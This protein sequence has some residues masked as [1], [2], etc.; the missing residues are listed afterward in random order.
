MKK[1][2]EIEKLKKI[3]EPLLLLLQTLL[4]VTLTLLCVVPFSCKV[5]EEGIIFVGGDYVS[6]VLEEVLVLDEKNVM[7]TFSEKIKL[8]SF[9]V[10][11]RLKEISDSSEH[12]DTLELSPALRAASGAYGR[13]E[14]ECFL[15]E[16]GCTITC[17]AVDRYEVG[18]AYE[19][20]GTV[21]DRAGNSLTYC[22]PFTG[23]N[24]CVPQ[25]IIT[26]VQI[27]GAKGSQNG[28]PIFR[29]EFVE[30]LALT[31]GNL[32]GLELVGGADGEA[33][34]Y[35][36]PPM[37]VSKGEVFLVHLRTSGD[38]CVN[39]LEEDLNAATAPHSAKGIR[40]LWSEN[41]AARLN[42]SSDV[43]I[44]RNSISDKLLDAFMYA[45]EDEVEWKKGRSELARAAVEAGIYSTGDISEAVLNVKTSPLKS[46]SRLDANDIR[47]LALSG[48]SYE[49]PV[50][51]AVDNWVVKE[52]SPGML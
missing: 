42:D 18:K 13:V 24:S 30:F 25:L 1:I 4:L 19:I 20:L 50:R 39:E 45:V 3:R 33:K 34:K 17:S 9:T 32:A 38:G 48:Q 52:T 11:E 28:N 10:S 23:F 35:L 15:S 6:P 26:E 12:S 41:T 49:Y 36:F 37:P 51:A 46:F 7:I 43:I 44:L 29:G 16:D 31:D 27:K 40:D 47:S 22:V 21:E 5:S 2:R 8:K 14:A